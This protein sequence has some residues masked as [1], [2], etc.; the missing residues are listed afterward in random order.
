MKKKVFYTEASYLLGLFVLTVGTVLMT[1]ADFGLSMVVAPAYL[2]HLKVSEFLPFFSF[3]MA[4]YTLQG[5]LLLAT[6]LLTGRFRISY[7]FSFFTAVLYGLMLDGLLTLSV[8][9]PVSSLVW[10]GIWY[11]LRLV[12]CSL[13]VSLL[14]HTYLPPAAYEFFVKEVSGKMNKDIH[15]FKTMYDCVSCAVAVV[16]SFL[17]FGFGHFEGVKW[18]TVLCALLNGTIIGF[19]A[20]RMEK[21]FE[22]RDRFPRLRKLF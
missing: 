1:R 5:V 10:R 19:F 15:R 7:L 16:M 18:G 21:R 2:L 20:H 11:A 13:G 6:G 3:G 22:F 9:L 8:F 17:F 14:F 4:E 12:T